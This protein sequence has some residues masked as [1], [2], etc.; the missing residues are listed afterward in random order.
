MKHK[1]GC[2]YS[3]HFRDFFL[4]IAFAC[5]ALYP[6]LSSPYGEHKR[7]CNQQVW[8]H[9]SHSVPLLRL[10]GNGKLDGV[11]LET[12]QSIALRG[13]I[14]TDYLDARCDNVRGIAKRLERIRRVQ[15]P[16]VWLSGRHGE[17]P[18]DVKS[19]AYDL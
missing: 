12:L 8:S 3:I 9:R 19:K 16:F 18:N 7:A 17:V 10:A 13:L 5:I 2:A 1:E 14:I 4:G 11:P 6:F 15:M